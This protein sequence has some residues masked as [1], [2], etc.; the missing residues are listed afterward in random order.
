VIYR[1][2][3][4]KS[5]EHAFQASKATNER[6]RA[7]VADAPTAAEAKKR[8]RDVALKPD[9]DEVKMLI[10]AELVYLKFAQ[11]LD[12]MEKLA[13]TG[14]AELIEGNWWGDTYWGVCRGEGQ[15]ILGKILMIVRK[16]YKERRTQ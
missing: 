14:E 2:H 1:D 12:L 8:G 13:A 16:M 3:V 5:V 9:W 10:M 6:D 11:N 15:N 4:Y 7:Y